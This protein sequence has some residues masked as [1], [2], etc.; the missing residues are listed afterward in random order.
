M[1][2][3]AVIL[4][5]A[6]SLAA[7]P[8]QWETSLAAAQQRATRENK[9]IFLDVSTGWC[10]W[11][12]KLQAETFPSPAGQ[13]ALSRVVPLHLETQDA[14]G[15]PTRDHAIESQFRVD[16]FPTLLIL[17]AD[18]REVARQQG[19]LPPQ[20]FAAWIGTAAKR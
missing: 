11:C 9:L 6:G 19:Y 15:K 16:V 7:A 10:S 12:K 18:G 4:L 14:A 20:Q 5:V 1:K 13:A 8:V 17:A 3:L 2:V